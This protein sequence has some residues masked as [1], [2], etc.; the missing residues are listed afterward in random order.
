MKIK[1]HKYPFI[2]FSDAIFSFS[3]DMREHRREKKPVSK[4]LGLFPVFYG[5]KLTSLA[6]VF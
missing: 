2:F 1:M 6:N 4:L 3:Y 5:F